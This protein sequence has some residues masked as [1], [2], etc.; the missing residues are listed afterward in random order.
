MNRIAGLLAAA[1]YVHF[2]RSQL[3][4]AEIR[5]RS[6]ADGNTPGLLSA[7]A[8]VVVFQTLNSGL[9]RDLCAANNTDWRGAL[10]RYLAR[11]LADTNV[12]VWDGLAYLSHEADCRLCRA[13]RHKAEDT[14]K[15]FSCRE[16]FARSGVK[17]AS[18]V[19]I[20]GSYLSSV[21]Q[22]ES[23]IMDRL[24][25]SG[26]D[27]ERA[28]KLS[29]QQPWVG[30]DTH[31]VHF[32]ISNNHQIVKGRLVHVSKV[33]KDS[34]FL[35]PVESLPGGNSSLA[36]SKQGSTGIADNSDTTLSGVTA[37][38]RLLLYIARMESSKGQEAFLNLADPDLL[39]H[40]VIAFYAGKNDTK[41]MKISDR[42]RQVAQR[43]N[44]SIEVNLDPVPRWQLQ[45]QACQADGLILYAQRDRNPRAL[46]EGL[47]AG[48]PL[49]VSSTAGVPRRLKRQP[50]VSV[51]EFVE[52][53]AAVPKDISRLNSQ[54]DHFLRMSSNRSMILP[55]IDNFVKTDL[56]PKKVFGDL[57]I[58]MGLKAGFPQDHASLNE[59]SKS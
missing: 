47:H 58:K 12:L 33:I 50:F 15:R 42:L 46:Y 48:L 26:S 32:P 39:Q 36:C 28:L 20:M 55:T 11:S 38:P 13:R 45:Q 44:I 35:K 49:L 22:C 37:R 34:S 51:V 19:V 52:P 7:G 57:T 25:R 30:K 29:L 53:S 23:C 18:D 31:I 17:T 16:W 59:Q 14:A 4:F 24:P 56:H 27:S 6:S 41:A 54:L 10:P 40:H 8:G 5:N 1:V 21:K 3:G 2:S 9:A 43:R